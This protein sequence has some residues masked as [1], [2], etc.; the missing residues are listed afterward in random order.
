MQLTSMNSDERSP[1]WSPDGRSIAFLVI[2]QGRIDIW[3]YNIDGEERINLTND[4]ASKKHFEW[5]PPGELL[6]YDSNMGGRWNIWLADLHAHRTVQLTEGQGDSMYPSWTSDG[7]AILFSSNR[8]GVFKIYAMSPDDASLRQLTNDAGNDIKP[9]M[10]PDGKYIAFVSDRQG[11]TTLWMMNADGTNVHEARSYPPVQRPGDIG[12]AP[13]VASEAYPLWNS[14]GQGVLYFSHVESD[15]PALRNSHVFAFYQNI[16]V[17]AY[18]SWD[19]MFSNPMSSL[20]LSWTQQGD[21]VVAMGSFL[22]DEVFASW[23]PDSRAI[24]YASNRD[25]AFDIWVKLLGGETPSPYG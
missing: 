7:R 18:L 13:E 23:G 15:S 25:G 22:D 6:V 16:S 3:V 21:S 10:S 12:F 8:S 20:Y 19:P 9:R 24:V 2:E 17:V 4:G 14:N 11:S 1:K 5:S